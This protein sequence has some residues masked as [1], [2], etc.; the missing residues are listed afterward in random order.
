MARRG[1]SLVEVVVALAAIALLVS[2]AALAHRNTFESARRER[3]LAELRRLH[4]VL[5]EQQVMVDL[6]VDPWGNEYTMDLASQCLS[7]A[8]PDGRHGTDDDVVVIAGCYD[9][10]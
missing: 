3:A 1:L 2:A 5:V 8:G 6:P 9:E 4:D 7:S 10:R